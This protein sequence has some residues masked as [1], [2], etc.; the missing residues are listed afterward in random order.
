M[1]KKSIL[2]LAA[3]LPALGQ[4][5]ECC[6][7]VYCLVPNESIESCQ[8]PAGYHHPAA[9]TLGN[10]CVNTSLS[11]EFIYWQTNFYAV[12]Q[13][14]TKIRT[15]ANGNQ[16]ITSLFHNQRWQPG[17][18]VALG[19]DF[20]CFDN[21]ALDAE[22]TWLHSSETNHFDADLANGEVIVSKPLPKLFPIASSRL[23]TH[24]NADLDLFYFTLGRKLYTGR[25]ILVK[26][27][28]G[29][30]AWW[31]TRDTNFNF[32]VIGNV[33]AGVQDS[34]H[35]LWTVGGLVRIEVQALLGMGMYM[36]GKL[37][38]STFYAKTTHYRTVT[39]YPI[40][41]PPALFP[42]AN[43][44]ESNNKNPHEVGVML[45]GGASIG[46]GTY[47]CC[48]NYHIEMAVGY[49][50]ARIRVRSA[51]IEMGMNFMDWYAQGIS[52]KAKFDF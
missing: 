39:N 6:E 2:M 14:G 30:Q 8:V 32:T 42:G 47:L 36:G 21:W 29:V 37:G 13:V 33:P 49:D 16:Q 9:L 40:T 7:P 34:K 46:W 48:N 10:N 45:Q 25:R 43:N 50:F 22:Y 52:V 23:R 38:I 51:P 11:G 19:L 18:R 17:F 4:S 41:V 12:A 26:T 1:L 44:V 15:Q 5:E 35:K 24:Q 28:A 31:F 3:T 20:P 27:S